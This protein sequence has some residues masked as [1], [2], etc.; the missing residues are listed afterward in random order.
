M[1]KISILL[2]L[3][4]ALL[5]TALSCE[6]E[7]KNVDYFPNQIGYNWMYNVYDSV[8]NKS[9]TLKISIIGDTK[10]DGLESKIWLLDYPDHAD[11]IFVSE[12]KDT[13]IFNTST[14]KKIYITPFF[15]NQSW[16]E[17]KTST[18]KSEVIGLEHI[19]TEA[20]SFSNIYVITRNIKSPNYSLSEKIYYKP[21]IGIIKLYSKEFNMGPFKIETWELKNFNF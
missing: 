6:K 20:G 8:A 9:E 1:I 17:L 21:T 15:V 11:T 16:E 14:V 3:N 7:N 4:G 18:N 2:F 5:F 10:T 19:T 12:N 13:V